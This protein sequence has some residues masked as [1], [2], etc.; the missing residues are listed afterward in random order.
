L[1]AS[2]MDYALPKSNN[3][4]DFGLETME[5]PSPITALGV[6]GIGELPTLAA[7]VAV[8]NAVMNALAGAGVRHIDTPLTP[9][10]VWQALQEARKS[11]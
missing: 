8:A 5:T 1:T 3:T 6:K 2:L 10:K 4:P 9:E 11:P 7:P